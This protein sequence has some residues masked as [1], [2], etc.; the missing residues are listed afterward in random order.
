MFTRTFRPLTR[1]LPALAATAGLATVGYSSIVSERNRVFNDV[2]GSGNFDSGKQQYNEDLKVNRHKSGF[3]A[4]EALVLFS[5]VPPALGAV[6]KLF[7][8]VL[9]LTLDILYNPPHLPP[10]SIPLIL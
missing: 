5:L 6:F 10:A 2:T 3:T 1:A 7:D 4:I 9:G 8:I